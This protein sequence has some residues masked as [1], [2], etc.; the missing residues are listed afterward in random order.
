MDNEPGYDMKR[1]KDTDVK[2][3]KNPPSTATTPLNPLNSPTYKTLR[4]DIN[5]NNNHAQPQFLPQG[6]K[7]TYKAIQGHVVLS[8]GTD[9]PFPL[10]P[11]GTIYETH[12]Q[13]FTLQLT[14][15]TKMIFFLICA[16]IG[17]PSSSSFSF[18]SFSSSSFSDTL[19]DQNQ[20]QT[21]Q[22]QQ[23]KRHHYTPRDQATLV[24]SLG[25]H[26]LSPAYTVQDIW[27]KCTWS[28]MSDLEEGVIKRAWYDTSTKDGRMVLA[29]DAAHRMT[30]NTGLGLNEGI[31]DVVALTNSLC[32]LLLARGTSR[33]RGSHTVGSGSSG[34][35]G[36]GQGHGHEYGYGYGYG[37]GDGV[38][39]GRAQTSVKNPSPT[40][41]TTTLLGGP[42]TKELINT[43][44]AYEALRRPPVQEVVD[45]SGLWTRMAAWDNWLW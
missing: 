8:P 35:T 3:R 41:T 12:G 40:M 29:G 30:P 5:N 10:L 25:H 21:Q 28:H 44:C 32:S 6:L 11:P 1:E 20:T 38:V 34:R 17:V 16:R 18:S 45:L 23:Q 39:H 15:S 36:A 7:A 2:L 33:G 22:T 31:Q 43:F 26:H 4:G 24:A 9:H 19:T 13:N 37:D 42:S 27:A 14:S